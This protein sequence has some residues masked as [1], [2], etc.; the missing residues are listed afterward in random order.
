MDSANE[1]YLSTGAFGTKALTEILEICLRRGFRYL[2]LSSGTLYHE[3]MKRSLLAAMPKIQFLVHNYFPTPERP[4][5]LNLASGDAQTLSR[6]R[7]HCR[8]AVDL[9][10]ELKAPFYSVH[11]GFCFNAAPAHLGRRQTELER[12]PKDYAENIFIESLQSLADYAANSNIQIFFENNVLAPFNLTDGKNDL[13]L[14]VT[15]EE[16]LGILEKTRRRNVKLLLDVGHLK[17]SAVSLGFDAEA[18]VRAMLGEIAAVHLSDNDGFSDSNQGIK[19][20]SWFWESILESP[21]KLFWVLEAYN[22][23]SEVMTSQIN[24]IEG[25]IRSVTRN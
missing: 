4:F 22:L 18:A 19:E 5:V 24:L 8:K 21:G 16:T 13:L 10:V 1:V 6:S 17:V 9:C 23:T 14:A 2:E 3:S 7:E 25:R 15:P 11:A 12:I 20:N